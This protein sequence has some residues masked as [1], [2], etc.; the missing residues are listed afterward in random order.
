MTKE[1]PKQATGNRARNRS[2]PSSGLGRIGQA[3]R[4]DSRQRFTSLMHH[5]TPELLHASF[6]KLKKDAAAGVDEVTWR[7]YEDGHWGRLKS[8]HD[9]VQSGKYRARRRS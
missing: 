7:E 1:N 5:L 2:L 4:R 6:K 8:L 3:A 9:R